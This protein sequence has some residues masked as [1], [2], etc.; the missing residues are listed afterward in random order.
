MQKYKEKRK[1]ATLMNL[2]TRPPEFQ[3]FA[4]FCISLS[5]PQRISAGLCLMAG[6]VPKLTPC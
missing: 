5:S 2:K 6:G 4:V 1:G 3:C